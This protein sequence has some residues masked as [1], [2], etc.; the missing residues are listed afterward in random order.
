MTADVQDAQALLRTG[1]F[2]QAIEQFT[3]CV[4]R[5]PA[6]A[7]AYQGRALARFRLK[8]WPAAVED[9][10][11]ARQLDPHDRENGVGLGMSLAM[12]HRVYEGIAVLEELLAAHPDYARGHIQ[13]GLLYYQL[14]ATRKGREQ[15]DRALA[16]RPSLAERQLIERVLGEQQRLDRQRYYRPD[17]EALRTQR[18]AAP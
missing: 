17:F 2:E 4:T 18:N 1:A 9:F 8:Q 10:T 7:A 15:L 12:D 3:A 6:N 16:C 5:D 13:L 11:T 14:C